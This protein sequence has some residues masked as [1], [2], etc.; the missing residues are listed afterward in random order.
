MPVFAKR[1]QAV[2]ELQGP[3]AQELPFISI[4]L[5]STAGFSLKRGKP[6]PASTLRK[7]GDMDTWGL[8]LCRLPTLQRRLIGNNTQDLQRPL[9]EC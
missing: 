4:T 1:C 3:P 6:H 9:L 8:F 5:F 7:P 2:P